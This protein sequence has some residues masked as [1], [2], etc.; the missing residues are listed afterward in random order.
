MRV[1]IHSSLGLSA[2]P[3]VG[4]RPLSSTT[5]QG[6]RKRGES[7]ARRR[8]AH[9]AVVSLDEVVRKFRDDA[10]R[11]WWQDDRQQ[12]FVIRQIGKASPDVSSTGSLPSWRVGR[13]EA[14]RL[15]LRRSAFLLAAWSTEYRVL[16]SRKGPGADRQEAASARVRMAKW[17]HAA[18]MYIVHSSVVTK[19]PRPVVLSQ[20]REP[21]LTAI[22]A[23]VRHARVK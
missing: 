11:I 13:T 10:A 15:V 16:G 19:R 7:A 17:A 3:T 14:N 9:P 22:G 12:K 8:H 21:P 20:Y 6:A 2:G 18:L 1:S 4:V 5:N 23:S